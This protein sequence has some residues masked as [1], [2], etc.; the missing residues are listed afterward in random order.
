MW[1]FDRISVRPS[2]LLPDESLR[3]DDSEKLRIEE[4]NSSGDHPAE[5]S[6]ASGHLESSV[7]FEQPSSASELR[8]NSE[9][10]LSSI[11]D[12]Q[13]ERSTSGGLYTKLDESRATNNETF[14]KVIGTCDG[15]SSVITDSTKSKIRNR[16]QSSVDMQ[17]TVDK[18]DPGSAANV[19]PADFT[20]MAQNS[21]L[22]DQMNGIERAVFADIELQ[23]GEELST[24]PE[25]ISESY[26]NRPVHTKTSLIGKTAMQPIFENIGNHSF[27]ASKVASQ[28]NESDPDEPPGRI[29]EESHADENCT[30]EEDGRVCNN[31]SSSVIA[32]VH[33]GDEMN[34]GNSSCGTEDSKPTAKRP[35]PESSAA[36]LQP[37]FS[38][39]FLVKK[40][41]C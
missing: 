3:K 10:E 33:I 29:H 34:T 9:E 21:N 7:D 31:V 19:A 2:C 26:A 22:K 16:S 41:S 39:G 32:D 18:S 5:C 13:D 17:D 35:D 23:E 24:A 37:I 12:A 30:I 4:I 36:K 14:E 8:I 6:S 20:E 40:T 1:C 28:G 15:L 27:S 38:R 11:L 25:E